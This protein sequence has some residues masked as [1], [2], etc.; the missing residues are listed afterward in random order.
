VRRS[1][2]FPFACVTLSIP[3]HHDRSRF[4]VQ[5]QHP[6]DRQRETKY[7]PPASRTRREYPHRSERSLFPSGITARFSPRALFDV[8]RE[9][10]VFICRYHPA[11]LLSCCRSLF[12]RSLNT[13]HNH[14]DEAISS[15]SQFYHS[16]CY[17]PMQKSHNSAIRSHELRNSSPYQRFREK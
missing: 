8:S 6:H 12:R 15:L 9:S 2:P 16:D 11:H 1:R 14:L 4:C 17:Y 7:A 10:S 3:T 13:R 5:S